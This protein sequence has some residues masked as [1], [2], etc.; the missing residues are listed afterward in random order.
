MHYRNKSGDELNTSTP[1]SV[2]VKD[3]MVEQVMTTTSS[4]TLGHVRKVMNEHSVHAMPVVDPEGT[5]V[6]VITSTDLMQHQNDETRVSQVM[7]RKV[8]T[9]PLY[10]EVALA[11]RVMVNHGIHHLIVT[12]EQAVVGILSSLDLL[13]LIEDHSF[14]MTNRPSPSKK[15]G[16]RK[17]S[18]S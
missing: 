2:R 9:V 8:Y 18:E 12:H 11:A 10:A 1:S 5:P 13:R 17:K 7:T 16:R 14:K 15:K 4:K 3:L 6:G